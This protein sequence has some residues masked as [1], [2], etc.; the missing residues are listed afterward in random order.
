VFE[1]DGI[2][3]MLCALQRDYS[4]SQEDTSTVNT[5]SGVCVFTT[6][7]KAANAMHNSKSEASCRFAETS[8]PASSDGNPESLL[9][10][11]LGE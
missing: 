1:L 2:P 8:E 11:V 10:L 3:P 9:D 5:P 4:T 7:N 6:E